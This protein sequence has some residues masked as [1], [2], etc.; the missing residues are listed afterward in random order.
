LA[1]IQAHYVA[2]SDSI[3]IPVQV[4]TLDPADIPWLDHGQVKSAAATCQE[5]LN[6]IVKVESEFKFV[7]R[8]AGLG[9]LKNGRP[10]PEKIP[11][12]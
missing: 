1:K 12:G 2:D 8:H 10:G 6:H 11:N 4:S 7:T 3:A 9:N 5:A